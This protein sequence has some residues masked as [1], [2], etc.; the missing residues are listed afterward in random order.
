MVRNLISYTFLTVMCL[1]V[2]LLTEKL[3]AHPK[4]VKAMISR[5]R[6][7]LVCGYDKYLLVTVTG[8][9]IAIVGLARHQSA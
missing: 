6:T 2:T 3:S 1:V 5:G 4:V 9:V 8:S 7:Q